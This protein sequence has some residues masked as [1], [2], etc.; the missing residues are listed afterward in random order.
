MLQQNISELI[1]D[2]WENKLKSDKWKPNI[3]SGDEEVAK[4]KLFGP[5]GQW[6]LRTDVQFARDIVS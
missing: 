2:R 5:G 4:V 3:V 1:Y 6:K